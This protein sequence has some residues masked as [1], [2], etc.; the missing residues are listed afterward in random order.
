MYFNDIYRDFRMG[1]PSYFS[2]IIK[3]YTNIIRKLKNCETLHH[4]FMDCNSIIYDSYYELEEIYKKNPFDVSTIEHMMIQK[5]IEKIE[6]YIS[7]ISP[8]KSVY[9]TFDG[10]APFAKMNQQRIRRYKT[11]FMSQISSTKK[12]WNTSY[13]TPGTKFMKMLSNTMYSH[14]LNKKSEIKIMLS[15]SD[16][17]GEGEHKIFKLI[18]D[19][20][21]STDNIAIYGLDSDLIMLSIFHKKYTKNIYVF[22]EAPNFKSVISS[23]FDKNE[24]LFMDIDKLC[25]CI[26]SEMNNGKTNDSCIYDYVFMC[27]FLGNDFLP[28]FP[29]LNLRTRGFQILLDTYF[30]IIGK[31]SDRCFIYNGKIQWKWVYLFINDI[32][33]NERQ[34]ILNE[35]FL[36]DKMDNRRWSSNTPEEIEQMITN[37]PIILRQDEKYICPQEDGWEKRYYKVLFEIIPTKENVKKICK[38]YVKGLEWVFNYYTSDCVDWKYENEEKAP[39]M[40]DI[41]EVLKYKGTEE[42]VFNKEESYRSET[43]LAYVLPK[44]KE[45]ELKWC[46]VRYLW[47]SSVKLVKIEKKE[48]MEIER[49]IYHEGE[50]GRD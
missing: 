21:Y 18:R 6:Y 40:K 50:C 16:E 8:L 31:Y 17:N 36:R 43:Q 10:V 30:N 37:I 5:V 49:I 38:N 1:I 14:F 11:A 29:S 22:R 34:Y 12:I 3:N 23:S 44:E 2:Y 4:L 27:F 47:E 19:N 48:L 20:D 25:N 45:C 39:L 42:E 41:K 24:N 13:I 9:I 15:C 28:H 32:A 46:F 33:K 26:R 35:Y 7:Y